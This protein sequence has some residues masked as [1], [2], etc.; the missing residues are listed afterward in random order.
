MF[1]RDTPLRHSLKAKPVIDDGRDFN[2][3]HP[4]VAKMVAWKL[5]L[6]DPRNLA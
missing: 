6:A 3:L 4:P 5:T 2:A 1:G